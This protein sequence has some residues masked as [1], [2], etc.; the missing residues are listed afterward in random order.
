MLVGAVSAA[1]LLYG[2]FSWQKSAKPQAADAQ[3]IL[4][5]SSPQG[6]RVVIG[7]VETGAVTPT[8]LVGS[9]IAEIKTLP[10]AARALKR[11]RSAQPISRARH[12]FRWSSR[13]AHSPT[14]SASTPIRLVPP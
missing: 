4:L 9:S 14:P 13:S 7:G 12:H 6:A 11:L 3:Q 2:L 8:T 1:A 10:S 5:T